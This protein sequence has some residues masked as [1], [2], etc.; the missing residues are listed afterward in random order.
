MNRLQKP[1]FIEL[2]CDDTLFVEHLVAEAIG[3]GWPVIVAP[4]MNQALFNHPQVQR[5]ISTLR[6]WGVTVLEPQ[7]ERDLLMMASVEEVV[8][9]VKT[10]LS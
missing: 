4:S 9:A 1:R 2:D 3:A 10:K 7:P 6:E 8:N 5:S